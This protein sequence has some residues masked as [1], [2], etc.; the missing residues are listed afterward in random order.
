LCHGWMSSCRDRYLVVGTTGWK[1]EFVSIA[2]GPFGPIFAI[3]LPPSCSSTPTNYRVAAS[4]S[5]R[6]TEIV[7]SN[8]I[9]GL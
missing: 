9:R 1:S 7:V 3:E 5:V 2:C 4:I 8:S 6:D